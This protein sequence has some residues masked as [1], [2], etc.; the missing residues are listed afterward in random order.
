MTTLSIAGY[1]VA[2]FFCGTSIL[3][4]LDGRHRDALNGSLA[5]ALVIVVFTFT[6]AR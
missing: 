4:I 2:L 1:L 5:L 3:A 6:F